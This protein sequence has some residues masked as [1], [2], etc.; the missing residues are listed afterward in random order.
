MHL[1]MDKM[2]FLRLLVDVLIV[3]IIFF[4]FID[5]RMKDSPKVQRAL[6]LVIVYVVVGFLT[7][8]VWV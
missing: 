8:L 7:R 4:G 6:V 2:I 1:I 5:H 3:S